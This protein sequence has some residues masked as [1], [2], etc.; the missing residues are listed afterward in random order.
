MRNS[1]KDN[2]K[3]FGF[4]NEKEVLD[5]VLN[6]SHRIEFIRIMF[7]DILGRPM[8]FS[9]P[10]DEL[11]NGFREGKGFD[12][13]SVA[14]FVRIEESDLVIKPDATTFRELPWEYKGFSEETH[15]REGIMFG[16]ILTPE[17]NPYEGDT[18]AAL[19]KV[20][21][22]AKREMS[23]EDFKCGPELEFFIFPNNHEPLPLDEG[24]YFFSGQ[25]GE[26]RKEI[27]LLLKRMGIE[28]EYD[29]YEVAHVQ[30]EIDL[31]YLSAMEMA[32]VCMI[33]RYM[34]GLM[35]HAREISAILCQ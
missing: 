12:G 31:K 5:V 32:D 26:I 2:F 8:D 7:P 16:D 33:F 4:K 22:K 14:G 11:E 18:R 9:F 30:H 15:W 34:A 3:T 20:L 13:S 21:N 28:T 35:L 27:Q 1:L 25:K 24:G 17:G 6:P 29:H 23:I 19:K 10:A